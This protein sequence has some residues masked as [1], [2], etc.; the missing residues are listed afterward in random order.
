MRALFFA[1]SQDYASDNIM[2]VSASDK[3]SPQA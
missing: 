3:H 1:K 2:E